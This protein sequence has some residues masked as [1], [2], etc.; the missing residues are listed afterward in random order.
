MSDSKPQLKSIETRI[1]TKS[2]CVW[3]KIFYFWSKQGKFSGA[4]SDPEKKVL[5][6]VNSKTLK[7]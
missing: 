1:E 3:N 2:M 5:K 4:V 7:N 6:V